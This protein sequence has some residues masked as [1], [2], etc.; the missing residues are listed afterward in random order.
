MRLSAASLVI[1]TGLAAPFPATAQFQGVVEVLQTQTGNGTFGWA[2]ADLTDINNDG[3]TD[4]IIGAIGIGATIVY[5]GA[6]GSELFRFSQPGTSLGYAVADAGDVN[7]DGT[8]DIIAG[9]V[10]G[11]GTGIA[12]VYS[13][14]DGSLIWNLAGENAG[15]RFGSAVS[16]AGDVDDDGRADLLVGAESSAAQ[17]NLS[18]RAYVY[19]G[20]TGNLIRTLE[21]ESAGDRFGGG[22]ALL[23]DLNDDGVSDHIVG[24]Y[25][26]GT[27]N[28]GKAYV[29]SG[30][31]GSLLFDLNPDA[32]AGVFGQFFVA[33]VGDV[34]ADGT[35]DIYVGDFNH[36]GG[37]G[38]AYVFS[39]DDQQVLYRFDGTG[40]D[41]VGPGR[42]AGDVDN[43][44][45]ADLI[46][47]F[48]TS[49]AGA[50]AAGRVSVFSGADGSELQRFVHTIANAQLGFDA[51]GIGDVN[52]DGRFDYLLS[53]ANGNTVY[54][55][56]G[57]V[58]RPAFTLNP[59][60]NGSWFN[61]AT[62]GQG[63]FIDIFPDIP[64]VFLAWFT[65]DVNQAPDGATAV[66]GHP[67]HRWLT[68]QGPFEGDTANLDITLTTGGLFD[69]PAQT[70]NDNAGSMVLR[71]ADCR[72]GT[73]TYD[74]PR[75]G[76]SGTVPITRIANDNVPLCET[77]VAATGR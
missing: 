27:A 5:S 14:T 72:N 4:Y 24:A 53:A 30:A 74:I 25:S 49:S 51:V 23:G 75:L 43:D 42:G 16:S 3:V 1:I 57:T 50:N 64:L 32:G 20:M 44:G 70:T 36:A 22:A 67:N 62:S 18:G 29:Y 52:G 69:D 31:D 71:F 55:V 39:G 15:D 10:N 34:D 21:A 7:G 6:D 35:E 48:Y 58:E 65:Y 8:N 59:G 2:V 73:L 9:A 46:V 11:S 60:L 13:G 26:A 28:G 40:V 76:L 63:F 45:H 66:V 56:A 68:A 61:Q 77:L 37:T 17:G 19:S 33:S 12:N 41:G 54:V 47:G 38:R